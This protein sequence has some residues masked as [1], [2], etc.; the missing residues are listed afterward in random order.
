MDINERADCRAGAR[1]S[2]DEIAFIKFAFARGIDLLV[3]KQ[4]LRLLCAAIY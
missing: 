4:L 2:V 3:D 1:A